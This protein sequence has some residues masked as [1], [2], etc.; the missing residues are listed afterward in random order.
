M[1]TNV[2]SDLM[3]WLSER[4]ATAT[5]R[6]RARLVP[7]GGRTVMMSALVSLCCAISCSNGR[8]GY[9]ELTLFCSGKCSPFMCK[10]LI[11]SLCALK[12]K[13]WP[14]SSKVLTMY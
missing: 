2:V 9:E 11:L 3:N 5:R 4:M 10:L 12:A 8:G 6:S 1:V 7:R 14:S 13:T